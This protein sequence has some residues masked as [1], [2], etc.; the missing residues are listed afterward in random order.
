M[1]DEKM[2]LKEEIA[3]LEAKIASFGTS[4]ELRKADMM[5]EDVE[6]SPQLP[7]STRQRSDD[8]DVSVSPA[9]IRAALEPAFPGL[10]HLRGDG[11]F[12]LPIATLSQVASHGK[13]G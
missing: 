13:N 8:K 11:R 3:S 7:S 6:V 4:S 1:F 2:L 10:D 12:E 5:V 9:T